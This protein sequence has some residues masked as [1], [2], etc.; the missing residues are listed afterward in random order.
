MEPIQVDAGSV[1]AAP[2]PVVPTAIPEKQSLA[3][4]VF[5]GPNG[6]RAGW[7]LLIFFLIFAFLNVTGRQIRRALR[8]PHKP[9]ATVSVGTDAQTT[10]KFGATI[11]AIVLLASFAMSKIEKRPLRWYGL[12]AREAFGARFWEGWVW[13]FAALSLL[14]LLLRL[15]GAFYFGEV[16]NRGSAL[17]KFGALWG[18]AFL[19]VGFSEEYLFRGY[20]QYTLTTGIGFWGA[21][22]A[23]SG[24]FALGHM[25]N[26]GETWIGVLAVMVQRTGNLWFPIG[27][28]AAW[29]WAQSFVYGVADSGMQ[30]VGTWLTPHIPQNKPW[31]LTGGSVGP[32]GSIYSCAMEVAVLLLV[33]WRFKTVRYP[34]AINLPAKVTGAA[35]MPAA[36]T[37]EAVL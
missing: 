29:D 28:H 15:N 26:P 2:S 10:L 7:R 24:L 32:E 16:A 18:L 17:L 35:V 9:P 13:G 8:G 1:Q 31:W 21:T 22:I 27:F 5:R 34:E 37:G 14:L 4:T 36:A 30:S 11:F 20:M 12:G 19:F 6:L 23:L 25:Q 3:R 33:M